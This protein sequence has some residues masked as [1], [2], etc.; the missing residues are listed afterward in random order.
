MQSPY[1]DIYRLEIPLLMRS[2]PSVAKTRN[3]YIE[4][5]GSGN[6]E[7]EDEDEDKKEGNDHEEEEEEE[8]E[9]DVAVMSDEKRLRASICLLKISWD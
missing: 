4:Q 1:P 9:E 6:N 2:A 7:D 5:E 3:V 8:E